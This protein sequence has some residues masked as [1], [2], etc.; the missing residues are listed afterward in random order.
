MQQACP[1][2]AYVGTGTSNGRLLKLRYGRLTPRIPADSCESSTGKSTVNRVM[3]LE[4]KDDVEPTRADLRHAH[5]VRRHGVRTVR[6]P[7]MKMHMNMGGQMAGKP[8]HDG[9]PM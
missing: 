6:P 7:V 9:H 3:L 4:N 2:S 1:R 5:T 8:M